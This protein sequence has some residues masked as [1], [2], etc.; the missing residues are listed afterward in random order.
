MLNKQQA[1]TCQK[2]GDGE[3]ACDVVEDQAP[4]RVRGQRH[5]ALRPVG[6]FQEGAGRHGGDMR[7]CSSNDVFPSLTI[8]LKACLL[9]TIPAAL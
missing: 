4:A 2:V 6:G 9:E 3:V 1:H 5:A 8:S 7:I